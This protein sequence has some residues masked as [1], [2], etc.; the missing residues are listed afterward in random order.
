MRAWLDRHDPNRSSLRRG[1]RIA[2]IATTALAV[3]M[4]LGVPQLTTFA[5]FGSLA[6]LLFA[7]F[8]GDRAARG[9]SF[10]AMS[11][12][13][14]VLITIGTLASGI[15]W[16]AAP[17]MV[18][19]GTLV[20]A[21]GVFSAAASG[22]VRALLLAYVL[23]VTVPGGPADILPRLEGWLIAA[24][25]SIPAALLLFPDH[26]PDRLR[27][28]TARTCRALADLIDTGSGD[29]AAA[30]TD[31]A[32][33][34]AALR[35]AYDSTTARPVGLTTGSRLLI[36]VIDYLDWLSAAALRVADRLPPGSETAAIAAVL[37][38]S[39]AAL[40]NER[41]S[42]AALD[43]A[44]AQLDTVRH[45]LGG[46]GDSDRPDPVALDRDRQLH[47]VAFSTAQIGATV[48]L[49][50]ESD[51]RKL[52][53]RLL[54]R[55]RPRPR[56]G[57]DP[58]GLWPATRSIVRGQAT[59]HSIPLRNALRMGVGLG[60]A[61]LIAQLTG[62]QHGF[63]VGLGALSVLRS[64]AVV[65]TT[66]AVRA[67]IGTTIGFLVGSVLILAI[68]VSPWVLWPLMPVVLFLAGFAPT[69]LS[70]ATG[71][72]AFTVTVVALFNLLQPT[73]WQVGIV[74][75]EDVA[76][77]CAAGLVAGLVAWPRGAAGALRRSIAEAVAASS[78]DLRASARGDD[79]GHRA[80]REAGTRADDA[81]RGYLAERAGKDLPLADLTPLV[82]AGP[83]LRLGA[84]PIQK[85][86]VALP[87]P[88]P[89][90]VGRADDLADAFDALAGAIRDRTPVPDLPPPTQV[91]GP[92]AGVSARVWWLQLYLDDVDLLLHELADHTERLRRRSAA[93]TS[94]EV[95]DRS[96]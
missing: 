17:S 7:D 47:T 64:A 16:A 87:S 73:G 20:S 18:V 96:R 59:L 5:V 50:V 33:A 81:F 60:L 39:A 62:V 55:H 61:V 46:P 71:Q 56:S 26:E 14:L 86:A 95:V 30:A 65:T 74:R 58:A 10:V 4:P 85:L 78:A 23:P 6:M 12:A 41:G 70:F 49:A 48:A 22:A 44:L 80:A 82:N 91:D 25:L 36:R 94:P 35:T 1:A 53:D 89:A 29:R 76:L 40:T 2:V 37:R 90:A 31:V 11:A 8:P 19:V 63:W 77:G 57:A 24:V 43:A 21:S 38:G 72:A 27:G 13:A 51:Q 28:L 84:F 9:A 42:L 75:V 88:D 52:R 45:R 68:G 34:T 79:S 83:R 3:T 69:S 93:S 54:G 66:T 92:P 15:G 67:L 32:A